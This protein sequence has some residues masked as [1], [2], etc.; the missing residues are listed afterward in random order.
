MELLRVTNVIKLN[1]L[2]DESFSNEAAMLRGT[3]AHEACALDVKGDLDEASIDES[4]MPF[5]ESERIF[6]R[7]VQP[8]THAQELKVVNEAMGY[9]GT[10]DWECCFKD[11]NWILDRKTGLAASWHRYQVALYALAWAAQNPGQP[12]PRRAALYLSH[13]GKRPNFVEFTDRRDF[14]RAKALVTV[15]YIKLELQGGTL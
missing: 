13:E 4:V 11:S 1:G 14:D 2:I 7:E 3:Y 12:M 15:A 9:K 10:L 8:K 6:R 5:V